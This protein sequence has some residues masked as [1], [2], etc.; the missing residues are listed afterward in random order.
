MSLI[1]NDKTFYYIF[2]VNL[3][4]TPTTLYQIIDHGHQY[5]IKKL[6]YTHSKITFNKLYYICVQ[7]VKM[8]DI[9]WLFWSTTL[10][11]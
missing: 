3:I 9:F 2:C 11:Y 8:Y 5:Y 4:D 6:F 1:N 7:N 10:N